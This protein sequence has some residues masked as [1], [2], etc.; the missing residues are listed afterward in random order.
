MTKIDII[1]ET[2]NYY[3]GNSELRGYDY[4]VGSCLYKSNAGRMCAVGRCF[5]ENAN[6]DFKGNVEEY[7]AVL[8]VLWLMSY[9]IL[10]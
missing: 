10:I 9:S 4:L 2:Y 7:M 5:N 3:T 1:E 8:A 6:F